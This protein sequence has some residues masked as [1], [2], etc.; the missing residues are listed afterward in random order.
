MNKTCE[1]VYENLNK[2]RNKMDSRD[3]R[4]VFESY[5]DE[6]TLRHSMVDYILFE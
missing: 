5:I 6:T 4:N 3:I 2:N 1:F